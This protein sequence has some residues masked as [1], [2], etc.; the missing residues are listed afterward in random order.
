V[1][2]G[3]RIDCKRVRGLGMGSRKKNQV[4]AVR[5]RRRAGEREARMD[6]N[7]QRTW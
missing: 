4:D 3:K 7:Y 1:G 6:S 2:V 5:G